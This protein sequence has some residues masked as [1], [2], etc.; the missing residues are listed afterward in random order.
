MRS[1]FLHQGE[2]FA[3]SEV[4]RFCLGATELGFAT[5]E[6]LIGLF[7]TEEH[8][9]CA[10]IRVGPGFLFDGTSRGAQIVWDWFDKQ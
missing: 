7:R 8:R 6:E 5:S 9:S 10:A 2:V 1:Q 3:L 4:K